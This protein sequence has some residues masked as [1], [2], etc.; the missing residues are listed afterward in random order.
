M[1]EFGNCV[2]GLAEMETDIKQFL[3]DFGTT[4]RSSSVALKEKVASCWFNT[5]AHERRG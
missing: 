5:A 3:I 4:V 1:V 2:T